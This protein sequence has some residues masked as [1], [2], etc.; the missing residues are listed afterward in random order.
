M[1][2][3]KWILPI[4]VL[5][6]LFTSGCFID[7]DDDDDWGNCVDGNGGIVTET[8]YVDGF[9]GVRL[10]MSADVRITQGDE[11]E[12]TVEGKENIIEEIDTDVNGGIWE[13][14]TDRCVTDVDYLRINITMPT[15]D[16][17]K[18]SG[19]G[20]IVG[21]NV[22]E[23]NDI[24][25]IVSGSGDIDVA[26]DMNEVNS[27]VSGSGEITMEGIT[28]ELECRVS[29]SG[30]V[31]AFDL[32]ASRA[33]ITVSGSGDVDVWVIDYLEVSISGSGDVSY[34]GYPTIDA[35]ISG[36]GDLNDAN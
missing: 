22:F 25:I 18:V 32:E 21:D 24:D 17:L 33:D 20:D 26:L 11:W 3:S 36:S 23:G 2:Y 1:K 28:D 14:D 4:M 31:S 27:R 34:R 6:V 12:V 7:L 5:T 30:D 29:G 15:I 8:L 10:E 16:Y 35:S 9:T 19:S 13:I